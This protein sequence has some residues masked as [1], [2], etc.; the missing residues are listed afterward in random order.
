MKRNEVS[1]DECSWWAK[2]S[3]LTHTWDLTQKIAHCTRNHYSGYNLNALMS[4]RR[5]GRRHPTTKH[6]PPLHTSPNHRDLQLHQTPKNLATD[7]SR[8]VKADLMKGSLDLTQIRKTDRPKA[9]NALDR[10][11]LAKLQDDVTCNGAGQRR[12]NGLPASEGHGLSS[13]STICTLLA[14]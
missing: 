6:L 1:R 8:H 5:L 10:T 3:D 11:Q 4:M 12:A 13:M 7:A 14:L 9:L 2:R